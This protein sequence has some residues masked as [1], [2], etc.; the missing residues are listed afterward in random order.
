MIDRKKGFGE[1]HQLFL[2]L[3]AEETHGTCRSIERDSQ[4]GGNLHP[5]PVTFFSQA[6][7]AR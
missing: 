3:T 6:G 5:L 7:C 2:K 1:A 4:T